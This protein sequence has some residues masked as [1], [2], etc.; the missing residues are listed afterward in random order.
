MSAISEYRQQAQQ[1]ATDAAA[2]GGARRARSKP[3]CTGTST[4]RRAAALADAASNGFPNGG[5]VTVIGGH[6]PSSGPF[7]SNHCAISRHAST[8][9]TCRPTSR[10]CSAIS[11]AC[12]ETTQASAMVRPQTGG[13]C[14]YLLSATDEI[15]LQRREHSGR[16]NAASTDQRHRKFQRRERST[17][18]ASAM[19]V[20]RPTKTARLYQL[21]TPAP[22]LPVADPCQEIAGCSYLANNP[23]STSS[24]TSFNGNGWSGTLPP[25][26]T[27]T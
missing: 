27:A 7:S 5:N 19:P 17:C 3:D 6:P 18:R 10:G 26:V 24:C 11:T 2:I 20:R 25:A 1:S 21:A 15:E 13:A 22:M 16:R 9:A 14:I 8:A 23:P 12:A 4:S